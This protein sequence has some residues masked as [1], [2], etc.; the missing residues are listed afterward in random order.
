MRWNLSIFIGIAVCALMPGWK[1]AM[2]EM[3]PEGDLIAL[4]K[5]RFGVPT[6]EESKAFEIFFRK[7]QEGEKA[8]LTP[9]LDA[10]TDPRDLKILIDPAYADLWE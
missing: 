8:D 2:A 1:T 7:I 5:V 4:A 9:E 10:V 6:P 3:T